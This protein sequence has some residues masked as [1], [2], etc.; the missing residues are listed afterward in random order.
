MLGNAIYDNLLLVLEVVKMGRLRKKAAGKARD[1]LAALRA[2]S[3]GKEGKPCSFLRP[4]APQAGLP[5]CAPGP[6][7]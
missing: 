2:A 1:G 5:V 7:E 6:E 3:P 4:V